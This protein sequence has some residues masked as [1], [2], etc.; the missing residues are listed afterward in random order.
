MKMNGN[1]DEKRR[2]KREIYQK[3]DKRKIYDKEKEDMSKGRRKKRGI[4][5]MIIASSLVCHGLKAFFAGI[6]GLIYD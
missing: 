2:R 5:N 6:I 4:S 1:D 3:E